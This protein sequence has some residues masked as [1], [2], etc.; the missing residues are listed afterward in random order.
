M[1]V[2]A[3]SIVMSL[4]NEAPFVE[5]AVA[6]ILSQ[7]FSDFE[8]LVIDDGSTDGGADVVARIA[9]PRIRLIRQQNQGLAGALNTG[10]RA[11]R[12]EW[13]A[14][15]DADDL[16]EPGRLAAQ[17][18]AV[19]R[20]PDLVLLGTNAVMMDE[21]GEPLTTTAHPTDD[22]TIR[23]ILFDRHLGNPFIHGSM[24]MRRAALF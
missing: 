17:F 22:P 4:Y 23:A 10:I 6:S 16:S 18:E 2:P 8:L 24:M 21:E 12:A 11:A 3:V 5:E 1:S 13:I 9:D 15:H 7:T 20:R 19:T 14:R